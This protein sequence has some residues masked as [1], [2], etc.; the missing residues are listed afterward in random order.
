MS[1]LLTRIKNRYDTT[2]RWRSLN[3]VLLEGEFGVD[4]YGRVKVGDGSTS[5]NSLPYV[6]DSFHLEPLYS[7]DFDDGIIPISPLSEQ[8]VYIYAEGNI[9]LNFEKVWKDGEIDKHYFIQKRIYLENSSDTEITLNIQNAEWANDVISP[10]WGDPNMHLYVLATWI[11]GRIILEVLDN[12]QLADN[13][14][15]NPNP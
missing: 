5:W 12:D 14:I 1:K 13:V 10:Q 2:A 4:E 8:V 11:G 6:M 15:N 9:T 3:P 7:S